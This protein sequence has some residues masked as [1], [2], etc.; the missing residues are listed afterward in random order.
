MLCLAGLALGKY[1]WMLQQPELI[2][3]IGI[4]LV[5]EFAHGIQDWLIFSKTQL[6][7]KQRH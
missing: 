6:T 4:S 5:S 7:N 3:G 2:G 1:P